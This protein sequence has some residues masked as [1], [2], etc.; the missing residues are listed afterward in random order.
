MRAAQLL[1]IRAVWIAPLGITSILIFLITLIYMGS[2]VNPLGHLKNLPVLVVN[3]DSGANA[4]G[5][6]VALGDQVVA[7][8]RSS[9]AVTSRLSLKTVS[10][11]RARKEMNKN[12]AYAAIVIPS[13]FSASTLNLYALLPAAGSSS[14]PHIQLLTNTRSG[15]VGVSLATSIAQPALAAIS[16]GIGKQL[17]AQ[18][19]SLSPAGGT[20]AA[21]NPYR[22][23]PIAVTTVAFRPLPAHSALGLSAFYISLL[24]I[25]CGFLGAVLVNSTVDSALGYATNEV[26]PK[27][28]QRAPVHISRWHT[29]LS[30]WLLA[31]GVVPILVSVLL[32]VSIGLLHMDAPNVPL[33]W[34][35][36]VFAAV[37]VAA[38]TLV[39]FA[40]LG[41]LGQVVAMLVFIYLALASSGGT[42]PLQALPPALHFAAYFEPLRQILDGVRAILYFDAAGDAGLTRGFLMTGIGLVF[43]LVVGVTVTR[44][45]DHRKLYRMQPE[46]LAY[47]NE[48]VRTYVERPGSTPSA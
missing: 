7:Q 22:A 25:M 8:L 29:L 36:S 31:V 14:V 28:Q 30:K 23:S 43:W 21:T 48:S 33:L 39:L 37:V 6:R 45:Y 47:V 24:T 35:F 34:V 38:G 11:E 19:A 42:M 12:A 26:G 2:V 32:V 46:L 16:A 9:P 27:W 18:A 1:R 4:G 17:S 41:A 3:E 44:W 13:D 10:F 40:A 15:S 5:S 20:A